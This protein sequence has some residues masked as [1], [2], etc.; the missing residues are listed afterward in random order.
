MNNIDKNFYD[1]FKGKAAVFGQAESW[2]S[3]WTWLSEVDMDTTAKRCAACFQFS[4]QPK[5]FMMGKETGSRAADNVPVDVALLKFLPPLSK[6]DL[7]DVNPKSNN[8]KASDLLANLNYAMIDRVAYITIETLG[9]D[10]KFSSSWINRFGGRPSTLTLTQIQM[11][12]PKSDKKPKNEET[13]TILWGKIDK[14][15]K[16]KHDWSKYKWTDILKSDK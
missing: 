7:K 9:N 13:A 3:T 1:L 2:E 8:R 15:Q 14:F 4:V 12:Y 6:T 11:V 5:A 10:W 16:G